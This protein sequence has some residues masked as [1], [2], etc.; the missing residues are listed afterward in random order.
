MNMLNSAFKY[1]TR[2]L[3]GIS[4]RFAHTSQA[5][6]HR[7]HSGKDLISYLNSRQCFSQSSNN[8]F[9]IMKGD[10]VYIGFDPTAEKLHLGSLIGIVNA[11]RCA[12]FGLEP[13][14]LVGGATGMIGDPS[15]KNKERPQMTTESIQSNVN[16]ITSQIENIAGSIV[17]SEAY[18]EFL[19][20]VGTNPE[21]IKFRV[22]N[23]ADFYKDLNIIQF[24]RE[25]GSNIRM[26]AMLSRETIKNR[27]NSEEGLSLTEFM[28]QSIQAY[29][30]KKLNEDFQV[31]VQLGGSDQWG[32]MLTGLELINRDSKK[33]QQV[34]NITHP[35]LTT[36]SGKKLGKSEGNAVFMC[37]SKPN[38]MYQYLVNLADQDIEPLLIKLSFLKL[39]QIKRIVENHFKNPELRLG[40]KVLA[41]T[42]LLKYC[43]VEKVNSCRFHSENFKITELSREYFEKSS[44]ITIEKTYLEKGIYVSQFLKDQNII[45]SKSQ[46]RR[47]IETKSLKVNNK[48]L[49]QDKLISIEEDIIQG[50]YMLLQTGKA[51]KHIFHFANREIL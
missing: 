36:S 11:L 1:S 9:K 40:H 16:S 43:D 5:E 35:L 14:Y 30:F 21:S 26:G 4:C 41:E 51:K 25:I 17:K 34:T 50:E 12:A 8:D 31:K 32:N 19:R 37:D 24:L 28:Y 23:N 13:I 7:R 3:L 49:L 48:F 18:L 27:I 22:L 42:I 2:R 45:E 46:L 20:E 39:D 10:K 47:L 33:T 6:A 44:K 15:G 29:D 38:L